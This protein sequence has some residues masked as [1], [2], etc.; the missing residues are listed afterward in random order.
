[1]PRTSTKKSLNQQID[2][3]RSDLNVLKYE[4][5]RAEADMVKL[6]TLV[7]SLR[8]CVDTQVDIFHQP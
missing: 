6:R 8:Q 2:E 5:S 4:Y 3:L 1:M 7:K